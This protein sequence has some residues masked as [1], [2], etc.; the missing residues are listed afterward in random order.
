[1]YSPVSRSVWLSVFHCPPL[2]HIVG[3]K[4]T[5]HALSAIIDTTVL[6]FPSQLMLVRFCPGRF[7]RFQ[8]ELVG[9]LRD[10]HEALLAARATIND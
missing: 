5:P 4:L 1:M 2:S 7:T 9:W 10:A 8:S 6:S 3:H